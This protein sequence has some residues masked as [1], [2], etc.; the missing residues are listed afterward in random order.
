MFMGGGNML[1][2]ILV[3]LAIGIFI[4]TWLTVKKIKCLVTQ[5]KLRYFLIV[6]GIAVYFND[7]FISKYEYVIIYIFGMI[8]AW[9]YILYY[10]MVKSKEIQ[11]LEKYLECEEGFQDKEDEKE[12]K[13]SIT[14]IILAIVTVICW[15]LPIYLSY[16]IPKD[17]VKVSALVVDKN[18]DR[19]GQYSFTNCT[20]CYGYEDELY[21]NINYEMNS[22]FTSKGERID[23]YIDKNNPDEPYTT[24]GGAM[25]CI[26]AWAIYLLFHG[27]VLEPICSKVKGFFVKIFSKK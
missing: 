21:S 23:V 11:K 3:T 14:L 18:V 25:F 1:S 10:Y 15:V 26:A 20:I 16:Y 24:R 19:M 27:F 13:L 4:F 6:L 7:F 22:I 2:I 5:S 17:Y 8:I 9:L 12:E